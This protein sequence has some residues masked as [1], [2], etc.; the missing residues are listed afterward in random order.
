MSDH[1]RVETAL[2]SLRSFGVR[3]DAAASAAAFTR[4]FD[5]AELQ[6]SSRSLFR[7]PPPRAKLDPES[8]GG[9]GGEQLIQEC[10]AQEE[11]ERNL[12]GCA[13]ATRVAMD[14]MADTSRMAADAVDDIVGKFEQQVEAARVSLSGHSAEWVKSL[15]D[16]AHRAVCE[17]VE[18]RNATLTQIA[19]QLVRD[20][21]T[22]QSAQVVPA[23]HAVEQATRAEPAID[24]GDAGTA[25]KEASGDSA[26][27]L[28]T[29][30]GWEDP[31]QPSVEPAEHGA[32][33]PA[34]RASGPWRPDIWI[35]EGADTS[36]GAEPNELRDAG[37]SSGG[38][39]VQ[40]A[41]A[42]IEL[43][44]TFELELERSSRW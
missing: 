13:Q 16:S 6:F 43:E 5:P 10:M 7:T 28:E 18:K 19:D 36:H 11:F 35:A 42:G 37:T 33:S 20:C 41:G 27:Q 4:G 39:V 32:E 8:V 15:G 2:R 17:Q 3:V 38:G 40:P 26:V 12:V 1:E 30:N 25:S 24:S 31:A 29:S 23:S 34:E 44:T 21:E 22:T 9:A 14:G